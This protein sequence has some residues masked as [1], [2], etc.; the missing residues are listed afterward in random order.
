MQLGFVGSTSRNVTPLNWPP[1]LGFLTRR[2]AKR[3][4]RG[5][6][7]GPSLPGRD[8]LTTELTGRRIILAMAL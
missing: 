5:L 4:I 2:L 3:P 7:P 6:N 8:A 1:V